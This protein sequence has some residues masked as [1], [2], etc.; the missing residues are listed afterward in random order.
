ML[1]V[2]IIQ[3]VLPRS[4]S[5]FVQDQC[6]SYYCVILQ[7]AITR[8]LIS[9][10]QSAGVDCRCGHEGG[11]EEPCG[12]GRGSRKGGGR[13][14]G[15]GGTPQSICRCRST[16]APAGGVGRGRGRNAGASGGC[17]AAGAG[18]GD[19]REAE[20]GTTRIFLHRARLRPVLPCCKETG[21]SL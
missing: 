3:C 13:F 17:G 6:L 16:R 7:D 1:I 18:A 5:D 9:S 11:E 12:R 4:Y 2:T 21:P 20:R 14:G 10:S 15:G 19:G 8:V